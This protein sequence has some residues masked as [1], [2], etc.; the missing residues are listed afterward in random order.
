[1]YVTANFL[2]TVA[3][4][5]HLNDYLRPV[6][7]LLV[8]SGTAPCQEEI[9]LVS[10]READALVPVLREHKNA[11]TVRLMHLPYARGY[12]ALDGG[13]GSS[14]DTK[15]RMP[16]LALPSL[17]NLEYVS[18]ARALTRVQLF[19][20]ETSFRYPERVGELQAMLRDPDARMAALSLPVMRGNGKLIM[21]S[22]LEYACSSQLVLK[23][24]AKGNEE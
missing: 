20:G 4:H 7:T 18:S 3:N 23:R 22:D 16:W 15:V 19:N 13:A 11:S 2:T 21:S 17:V 9:L 10:D 12:G 14:H 24:G 1:V 6:D 8:F 5:A